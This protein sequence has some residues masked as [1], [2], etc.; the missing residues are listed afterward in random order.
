MALEEFRH[1]AR[2][3]LCEKCY[4]RYLA[5]IEP[6]VR[7][8]RFKPLWEWAEIENHITWM[9]MALEGVFKQKG[10]ILIDME[11]DDP[12]EKF[13]EFV[14]VKA[15]REIQQDWGFMKKVR[16][17]R[18]KGILRK[19]SLKL[20]AQLS[21][22]RNKLHKYDYE[23]TEKELKLFSHARTIFT[24]LGWSMLWHTDRKLP[25]RILNSTESRAERLLSQMS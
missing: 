22:I 2:E 15:F 23:F 9:V 20:L 1:F 13:S 18:E 4:M 6:T 19:A 16:Y 11:E 10:T 12:E 21:K 3:H 14:N 17:L 8:Y 7:R 25:S 24:A 5:L